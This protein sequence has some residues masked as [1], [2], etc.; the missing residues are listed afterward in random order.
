[1]HYS[2]RPVGFF[3]NVNH[4]L[5]AYYFSKQRGEILYIDETDSNLK[6]N[7]ICVFFPELGNVN[8]ISIISNNNDFIK[9]A[10]LTKNKFKQKSLNDYEY[11]QNARLNDKINKKIISNMAK[12]IFY[13]GDF[14]YDK[15]YTG[16]HIRLGDKLE[17]EKI[18]TDVKK[19]FKK[20]EEL[21]INNIYLASDDKIVEKE[22]KERNFNIINQI[23]GYHKGYDQKEFN[24]INNDTIIRDKIKDLL[25]DVKYLSYST[26]F[27]GDPASNVSRF[28]AIYRDFNNCNF[29]ENDFV[30][31]RKRYLLFYKNG[32]V[33]NFKSI[34]FRLV[35]SI[36]GY[37]YGNLFIK[38]FKKCKKL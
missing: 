37:Y 34:I 24:K 10:R 3:S 8:D 9:K 23:H 13:L 4:I 11:F 14:T 21:N 38:K 36:F 12:K 1:M 28:V 33:R 7:S 16:I 15:N 22:I 30:F 17:N 20:A 2:L 5:I 25:N 18:P 6:G 29:L 19:Y 31:I 35:I 26:E 32:Q 27:I